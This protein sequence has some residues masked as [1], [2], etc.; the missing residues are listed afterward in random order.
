M[1]L[2]FVSFGLGCFAGGL[3]RRNGLYNQVSKQTD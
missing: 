2:I 3:G 1:N